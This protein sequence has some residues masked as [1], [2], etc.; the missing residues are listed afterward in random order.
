MGKV[1][2]SEELADQQ[3]H[4]PLPALTHLLQRSTA[5]VALYAFR[6]CGPTSLVWGDGQGLEACIQV[7]GGVAH[8]LQFLFVMSQILHGASGPGYGFHKIEYLG[9]ELALRGSLFPTM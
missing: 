4:G 3:E 7:Q 5:D 8:R 6:V 2:P 9:R 1:S